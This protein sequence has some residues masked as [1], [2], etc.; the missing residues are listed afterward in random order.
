MNKAFTL[1]ELLI[2]VVIIGILAAIAV[3]NF[4][5]AQTRSKVSRVKA[6]MRAL[7]TGMEAY[8]VD[9]NRYPT[10]SNALGEFITSPRT[11]NTVSPYETKIPVLLTTPVAYIS[12]RTIDPFI[13]ARN[14]VEPAYYHTIV[15]DFV[16]LKSE[17][18][19]T[20]WRIHWDI[21]FL[22]TFNGERGPAA[23]QYWFQSLGPDK[24][25]DANVPHAQG[26][27]NLGPHVHGNGAIYDATNGTIS[28]GD[29]HYFGPG[30][31]FP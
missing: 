24:V 29:I 15:R 20:N 26:G 11:D 16:N 19:S 17:T 3:P 8:A 7:S 5:E 21:F 9:H 13:N 28:G 6:D 30:I 23:T 2:V 1:I 4:L 12:A 22:E 27:P 31:G 10:P 14:S 18:S 25:H